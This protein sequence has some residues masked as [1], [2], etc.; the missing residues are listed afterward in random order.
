M[1][2]EPQQNLRNL[3][4]ASECFLF[5]GCGEDHDIP[6]S[7]ATREADGAKLPPPKRPLRNSA[8]RLGPA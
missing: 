2:L 4:G 1:D 7:S 3:I 8:I 6:A 5:M